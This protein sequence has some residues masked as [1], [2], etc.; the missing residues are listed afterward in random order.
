MLKF[1]TALA[2][3]ISTHFTYALDQEVQCVS[4]SEKQVEKV[5]K[6]LDE[7]QSKNQIPVIDSF[8]EFC[9]DKYPKPIFV[10][11]VESQSITSTRGPAA[12]ITEHR[13]TI[14]GEIVD[15]AY[16][17]INGKNLAHTV[18]CDTYGVSEFLD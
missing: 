15:L 14:N 1:F 8:C 4:L 7:Y 9:T 16:L 11:S 2:L 3:I 17:Y 10:D 6:L 12:G 18:G 13:I 5:V